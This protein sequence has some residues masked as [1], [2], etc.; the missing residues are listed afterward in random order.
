MSLPWLVTVKMLRDQIRQGENNWGKVA[1]THARLKD[2]S[3]PFKLLVQIMKDS[4]VFVFHTPG[5]GEHYP[6]Y[7][8]ITFES[9]TQDGRTYSQFLGLAA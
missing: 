6:P 8:E 7:S 9:R 1:A 5:F 2:D 3:K 4:S